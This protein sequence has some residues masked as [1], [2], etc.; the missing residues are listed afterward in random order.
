MAS[1]ERAISEPWLLLFLDAIHQSMTIGT[2]GGDRMAY[3]TYQIWL[4][5]NSLIFE[6]ELISVHRVLEKVSC[7][8]EEYNCFDTTDNFLITP[9][10]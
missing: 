9:R 6:A 4:S 8:T 2:L 7:L 10:S 5:K 1:H 3:I